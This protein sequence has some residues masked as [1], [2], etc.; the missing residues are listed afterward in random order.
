MNELNQS[1]N[2]RF[3]ERFKVDKTQHWLHQM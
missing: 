1:V 2:S 3:V